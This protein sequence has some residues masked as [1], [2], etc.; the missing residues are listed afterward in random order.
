[1]AADYLHGVETV[2]YETGSQTV[3]VVKTSVIALT[4][5]APT[6]AKNSLTLCT[7]AADDAQFG[8][9]LPGFNIPKTLQIIRAIAGST[10]VLVVNVF[11]ATT[12]TAQVS[13]EP[14]TVT[15]GK[16]KLAFAPIGAVTIFLS[17]GTTVAPIVRDTDYTFDAFGNFQ[18]ISAN[19][20]NGTV[21]KFSYKKLDATTVTATLLNGAVDSNNNRT[22]MKL[23]DLAYNTFGFNPKVF[24]TP[25]YSSLSA[26]AAAMAAAASKFR[27]IYLLDAPYGTTISAAISGRGVGGGLVF[28]RTDQRAFLLYPYLK[29]YDD[30]LQADGDYP[31]SAFMAGVLAKVDRDFG[32]WYSP[33]NKVITNV[34]GSERPIEWRINDDT[35]EANRLNG[36]GITT[37]AAGYGTG[38][39]TWGNRNAS[40]P[41]S[42]GVKNFV[43][44][45][46]ADDMV[47]ESMELAAIAFVDQP[48][49]QAQIDTMR[50][51]GNSFVRTLI[52]RGACLPGS[53]IV[54]N[55]E[56]N[57]DTELANGHVVFER[58]YMF[59]PPIERITYK[60]VLDIS[61]LNS[62][63]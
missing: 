53:R 4:G 25:E 57:S 54:Y 47:I 13:L 2:E 7:T 6:G 3:T 58:I 35:C 55:K 49:A 17:D 34:T 56:D 36:A 62:I 38:T 52:Q 46:R 10:P 24:I 59:P 60:D 8:K 50:E 48:L 44:I 20:T 22:G 26:V 19:V 37:I 16:L 15:G 39:R 23:F 31:Y 30:Y 21:Y 33:S 63:S 5:I 42:S 14:Q 43:S 11:D 40:F 32:Y 28:N 1:M 18:V 41:S 9:A 29:T 51:S 45:R 61:L 27:S 12:N